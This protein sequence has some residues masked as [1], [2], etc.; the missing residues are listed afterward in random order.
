MCIPEGGTMSDTTLAES[1]RLFDSE[2]DIER[3]WESLT[4][5]NDYVF[6]EVLRSNLDVC[7]RLL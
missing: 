7:R 5:A 2:K 3:R 4:F 1:P 6:G